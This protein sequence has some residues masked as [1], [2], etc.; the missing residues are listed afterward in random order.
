MSSSSYIKE[1]SDRVAN[2]EQ[3]RQRTGVS[4]SQ[5]SP[6]ALGE[7][8]QFG[9]KRTHSMSENQ[10]QQQLPTSHQS[11]M[12]PVTGGPWTSS[13]LQHLTQAQPPIPNM[14]FPEDAAANG[15]PP[16]TGSEEGPVTFTDDEEGMLDQ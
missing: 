3:E 11:T 15:L 10:S 16:V 1:L 12:A 4:S 8:N 13:T 6:T 2:L 14:P 7:L 9:R 5:A